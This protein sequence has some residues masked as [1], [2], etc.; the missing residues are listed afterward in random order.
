MSL[1]VSGIF[2]NEVKVF[3]SDDDGSVHFGGDDLSGQ[4]AASDGDHADE[5]TFLVCTTTALASNSSADP[6]SSRYETDST[7]EMH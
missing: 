4:D 2:G 3:S 7:P 1:L 6:A 5:G